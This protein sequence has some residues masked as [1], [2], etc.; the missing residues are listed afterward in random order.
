MGALT[1]NLR[2]NEDLKVRFYFNMTDVLVRKGKVTQ[3]VLAQRKGPTRT[4]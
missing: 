4:Q 2:S 1:R 3:D